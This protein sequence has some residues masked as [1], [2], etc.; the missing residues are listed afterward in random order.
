MSYYAP[1]Y[2]RMGSWENYNSLAAK[3]DI[4]WGLSFSAELGHQI[5]G[6]PSAGNL[7]PS[8]C[9]TTP[10]PMPDFPTHINL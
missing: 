9:R 8:R 5:F 7:P 3:Y 4:G 1:D 10:M 2:Y 6:T